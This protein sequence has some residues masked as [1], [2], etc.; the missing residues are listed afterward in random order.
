MANEGM[1]LV[2]TLRS[3]LS[4]RWASCEGDVEGGIAWLMGMVVPCLVHGI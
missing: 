2:R 4:S 1:R 3:E